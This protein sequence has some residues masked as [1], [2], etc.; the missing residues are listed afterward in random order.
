M[1]LKVKRIAIAI[2]ANW[3]QVN[4]I[5]TASA[6]HYR[7]LTRSD[8]D[9]LEALFRSGTT[10]HVELARISGV[11]TSTISRELKRG[12]VINLKSSLEQYQTYSSEVARQRKN[13]ACAQKGPRTKISTAMADL[14]VSLI[15]LEKRSPFDALA[16]LKD[17]GLT[18]LPCFKTVYNAI[19]HGDLPITIGDLPYRRMRRKDE[20]A[21]Y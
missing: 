7:H 3:E 8:R 11:H 18:G 20:D 4:L 19:H 2:F 21:L 16:M 13:E 15:V 5:K 12:A 10:S 17:R 9:T 1:E 6:K 14:I